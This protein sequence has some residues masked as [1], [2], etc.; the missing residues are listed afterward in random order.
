MFK[1]TIFSLKS[2]LLLITFLNINL[3]IYILKIKF[4]KLNSFYK[5]V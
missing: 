5:S 1:I 3:I 4:S 2:S